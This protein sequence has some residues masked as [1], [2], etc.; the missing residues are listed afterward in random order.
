MNTNL[1]LGLVTYLFPTILADIREYAGSFMAD[2]PF[3]E[4]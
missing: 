4:L 3:L 1:F 2:V